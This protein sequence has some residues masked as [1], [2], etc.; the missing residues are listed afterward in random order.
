MH[1]VMLQD[2]YSTLM[3]VCRKGYAEIVQMLI[4]HGA[5]V[6]IQDKV[7][8]IYENIN[9]NTATTIILYVCMYLI[10]AYC[11]VTEWRYCIDGSIKER[12]HCCSRAITTAWS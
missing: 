8:N 1:I 2:G 12:S 10:D 11:C 6:N 7:R 5:D 4:Q 9:F 3:R